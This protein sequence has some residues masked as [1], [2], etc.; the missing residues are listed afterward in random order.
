MPVIIE[1]L[2]IHTDGR[3]FVFE[4]LQPDQMRHQNNVHVVISNP[5]AVRGNH[6]HE[7]GTETTII[8]GPALLKYKVNDKTE[9]LNIS[10]GKVYRIVFPPQVSHAIQNTGANPNVLVAFNT[11]AHTPQT[12]DVVSDILIP[13]E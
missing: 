3:G 1:P 12:P 5:G 8:V 6:F 7:Y 11:V 10:A 2:E 13:E 4:P 9:E